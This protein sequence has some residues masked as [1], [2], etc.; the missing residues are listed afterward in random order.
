MSFTTLIAFAFLF[1]GEAEKTVGQ[2]RGHLMTLQGT[3]PGNGVWSKEEETKRDILK[4]L[5]QLGQAS[6]PPLAHA[7]KDSDVQ[8]RQ[9]AALAMGWLAGGYDSELRPPLDIS[10]AIPEL[11][12]ALQ[13]KDAGVRAWAAGAIAETGS[14][15]KEAIA[16]LIK[17]LKD[18]DEG[19]RNQG[20]FALGRIGA[21]ATEALPALRGAMNDDPSNVV[22]RFA[23]Q[24][25]DK[26]QKR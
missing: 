8:M 4:Q 3:A 1:Q 26:I 22:R 19:P 2:M 15:G 25:I 18:P 12:E 5:H 9:D 7:L 21:A 13:D 23:Q 6:I 20:C 16:S 10:A 17:L 14:N 24:A 11:I